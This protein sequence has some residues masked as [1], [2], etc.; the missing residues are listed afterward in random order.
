MIDK[1]HLICSCFVEGKRAWDAIEVEEPEPGRR[2]HERGREHGRERGKGTC[3]SASHRRR[4]RKSLRS[5]IKE[6]WQ[7]REGRR[8]TGRRRWHPSLSIDDA[9]ITT[10]LTFHNDRKRKNGETRVRALS[11]GS[12]L[13][14]WMWDMIWGNLLPIGFQHQRRGRRAVSLCLK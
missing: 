8:V 4:K 12:E 11:C 10:A 6:G 9:A 3:L 7:W 5:T 1:K 2:K 13:C 14:R